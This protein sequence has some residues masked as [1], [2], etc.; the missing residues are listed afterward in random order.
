M[1][2]LCV[3]ITLQRLMSSNSLWYHQHWQLP[4]AG[5]AST[6]H[7][8]QRTHTSHKSLLSQVIE[9][10]HSSSY[11]TNVQQSISIVLTSIKL[12]NL[13]VCVCPY[14][15]HSIVSNFKCEMIKH[16]IHSGSDWMPDNVI[17]VQS[18]TQWVK[19]EW[20]NE[21]SHLWV[22]FE[23]RNQQIIGL[24]LRARAFHLN[25]IS[26]HSSFIHAFIEFWLNV[27]I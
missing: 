25:V 16:I 10:S 7:H 8:T 20:K 4:N 27:L 5:N 6:Y 9:L 22:R 14:F 24:H 3:C 12:W 13:G 19:F 15:C 2:S 26:H 21:R 1:H 17:S 23:I 11:D 18:L